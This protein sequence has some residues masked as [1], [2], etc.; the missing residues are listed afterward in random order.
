[1]RILVIE[2]EQDLLDII[3]TSL[4]KEGYL[5]EHA[6]TCHDGLQKI[7]DYE[8][9]C[10]LL[11]I[12]LPDG[13]GLSLIEETR[14][15]GKA[16]N[17]IIISAKDS[18]DDKVYGLNLGADDYLLKPFHIAELTARIN[19]V[20]RRK[21]FNGSHALH[22]ENIK[23]DFQN[24]VVWVDDAEILLNRK[25][26]DILVYLVLNKNRLVNKAA[27]AE[28][29]WGNYIDETDDF[30]FIYAQIKNLRKKLKQHG[31]QVEVQSVYGI[32]YK[33]VSHETA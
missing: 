25:E 1:M 10:I 14:K 22:F 23:I 19:S 12:M 30:E 13:N 11:D 32:G 21:V 15:I 8:Y 29:V 17:T 26:F 27:L 3:R 9:D 24:R 6:N 18:L 5:V 2:D 16:I 28:H 33:L 31:A 7:I 4:E 20:L